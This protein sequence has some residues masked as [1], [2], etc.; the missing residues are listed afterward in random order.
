MSIL[1]CEAQDILSEIAEYYRGTDLKVELLT[2]K[3]GCRNWVLSI[4]GQDTEVHATER[5]ESEVVFS[6]K[7]KSQRFGPFI[8]GKAP[9][10]IDT[11][12][13]WLSRQKDPDK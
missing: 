5:N 8:T 11:L 6:A 12:N 10:V 7:V 9:K 4:T 3:N 1:N 13:R 2:G